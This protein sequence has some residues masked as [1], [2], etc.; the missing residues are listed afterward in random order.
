[1]AARYRSSLLS[2]GLCRMAG[3]LHLPIFVV[4]GVLATRAFLPDRQRARGTQGTVW[5]GEDDAMNPMDGGAPV[6]PR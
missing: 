5:G 2:G 4:I 3:F 1:M 6:H